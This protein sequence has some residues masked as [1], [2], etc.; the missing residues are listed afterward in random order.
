MTIYDKGLLRAMK[1]AYKKDGYEV[2]LNEDELLIQTDD[3][4]VTIHPKMVP[5][6]IKSL[7]V[8]HYGAM[9]RMNTAVRVQKG[10][11]EEVIPAV[12]TDRMEMLSSSYTAKGGLLIKPTRLT[13]D[14][15]RVWQLTDT[16]N[17]R[18]VDVDNQ[19]I[20][21][22]MYG[23]KPEV[24][25]VEG[26]IYSRLPYGCSVFIRPELALPEDKPLLNHLGQMQWIPVELA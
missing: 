7:I 26:I 3:W 25:L 13:F 1:A 16:F 11:C 10:E 14:G 9:P 2:A 4:G 22:F 12:V 19:Q 24:Y 15:K 18:L 5:N 21:M 6:S 8:L 20:L 17:V 23:E